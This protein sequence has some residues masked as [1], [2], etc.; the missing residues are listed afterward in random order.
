MATTPVAAFA[1]DDRRHRDLIAVAAD[2]L[3]ECDGDGRVTVLSPEFEAATGCAPQSL[4][5][6]PIAETAAASEAP[7]GQDAPRAALAARKPIRDLLLKLAR[8]DGAAAWLELAGTPVLAAG[9]FGGYWG[10]GRIVTARVEAERASQRY[11]ELFEVASDWFWETDRDNRLTYVSPNTEAVFGLP[12]S[13][14][15][16]KRLVDVEG[17][18]IEPAAGHATLAAIK[19]RQPYHDFLYSRTLPN[20]KLV[21][22]NSSGAPFYG[23]DGAFQGFRGIARDVTAQVEVERKRHLAERRF[24]QMYEV[25][26]DFYW[27]MDARHRYTDVSPNWEPI[28][29][30]RLADVRGKTLLQVPGVFVTPEMGR[31]VLIAQKKKQ[32]FRDFVYSRKFPTGETRWISVCG[33]PDFG[34]DGAFT[35]YQGVGVDITQRVEAEVKAGLAQQRL[36]DAVGCVSQPFVVYDAEDRVVAFNPA[37]VDL[38][39][40]ADGRYAVYEGARFG[41]VAAWQVESGFYLAA[42]Q[43]IDLATLLARYQTEDE[44]SYQLRDG[45]WMLV[46]YRRLPGGGRVGI[47]TDITAV[48]RAETER[49][50]LE[51]QLHH[52]QRLEGLGALAGGVAHEINNALVPVIALSKLVAGHLPA[53]SRDRRSL[54]TVLVG[55]ERSRDLVKQILAFSRKE[56]HRAE[57]VDV[58]AVLKDALQ[59]MR[60]TVPASIRLVDEIATAPPVLGD[61]N[62]LHQVIVN[63][64]TNAAHAI[65]DAHGTITV[66]LRP[67]A[68]GASLRLWIADTGSGMDDATK[69]RIFEPFFTTKEVGKGTGL[70]LS[71]A[72]GIIKTHDGR[73]EVESTAGTGT[74]FDIVLPVQKAAAVVAA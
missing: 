70:G 73:I 69:A 30:L 34:E 67:E 24:R 23:R 39:R 52:S 64:V 58:A 45:R 31:S 66:G 10:L 48:K 40:R 19:A 74:R 49:R 18:A 32:P 27:E 71:V 37:F 43:P 50:Q 8:A 51:D 42:S 62:Q 2:W 11:R 12:V 13:H 22:I 15:H 9:S 44:H 55:A 53:E 63:L 36:H 5:G 68:D 6:M 57:S 21:W 3:W 29:G 72:H 26:Y 65:G 16:G 17:V 60:V 54:A 46:T 41:D 33:M 59:L 38:H 25:A 61:P 20:G 14:Y 4:L 7:A 47:W 35:G 56:E 1:G 28:H